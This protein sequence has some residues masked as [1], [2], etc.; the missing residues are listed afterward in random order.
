MMKAAF[1]FGTVIVAVVLGACVLPISTIKTVP[2]QTVFADTQCGG[3]SPAIFRLDGAQQWK[4]LRARIE[5]RSVGAASRNLAMPDL[6]RNN[7]FVIAMGQRPT[8]G[9]SVTLASGVARL[10]DTHIEFSV[11][12]QEPDAGTLQGQ[13]LTSPC[14]VVST[15][16]G[17]YG[18]P[19]AVDSQGRERLR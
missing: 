9:Y 7:V 18:R 1:L 17:A 6:T 16:A 4:N 5:G 14:V 8:L 11:I 10:Y 15:P 12:W 13:M 19:I 2:V 3:D